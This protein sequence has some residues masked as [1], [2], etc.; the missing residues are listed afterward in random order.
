MFMSRINDILRRLEGGYGHWCPGCG[1]MHYIAVEKPLGNG[2]HW[3]F[4]G[5]VDKPTFNP[6]VKIRSSRKGEP[7][8]CHYFIKDGQIE[9][10]SDCTHELSGKTVPIPKFPDD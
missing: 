2:A 7:T 3:G 8:C 5:D 6:S 9:F 1:Q 4:N 10:C